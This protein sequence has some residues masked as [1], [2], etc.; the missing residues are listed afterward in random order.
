ML[1]EKQ[2]EA[3]NEFENDVLLLAGAGS[4]KTFT[5]AQK[6]A[7]ATKR[8]IGA[9]EILCLT[10]T[11]KAADE[12]REDATKYCGNLVPEVF[13]IH[14]FC[15]RLSLEYGRKTGRFSHRQIADEIDSGELL[16]ELLNEFILKGDYQPTDKTVPLSNKNLTNLASALKHERDKLGFSFFSKDGYDKAAENLFKNSPSFND[17]F[18]VKEGVSKYTDENLIRF[19][20]R[21]SNEFMNAYRARLDAS[22][23]FDFDD[24]IFCAKAAIF[25]NDFQKPSYKLIIVDEMQD[26]SEAEYEIVKGFFKDSQVMMC[27]DLNQ[28]IYGW[29]GSKPLDVIADFKKNR[30]VK[31]IT[32]LENKRSTKTLA[33]ASAYYL[34]KAFNL[35][36]P[37]PDA[38]DEKEAPLEIVACAG[39]DGEAREIFKRAS[40][41]KG[42]NSEFCVMAR[43]NR[44]VGELYAELQK[45]NARLPVENRLSFFTTDANFQFYKKPIVKDFLAFFR[46][47]VNPDD[48]A[49]I[50]RLAKKQ[51]KGLTPPMI[52]ALK[53]YS[54]LGISVGQFLSERTYRFGDYFYPLIQA[55]RENK[56][57][58]YDLE[59]TGL[60]VENDQAAQISAV[61]TGADGV[62]EV[63]NR[64]I[65]PTKEISA[66][67]LAV[68]GYD[69]DYIE[70]NGGEGARS[71]LRDFVEFAD[72]SV[73]VGHNSSSFDD[74]VLE[75][76][77]SE[78]GIDSN[79]PYKYDTLK[80]VSLFNPL[81]RDY[82]LSTLC[83]SFEITNERA[84]D[85]F[86]DV[87]ATE[88]IL[89][90]LIRTFLIPSA[91]SRGVATKKYLPLFRDLY[92]E[93]QTATRFLE[94]GDYLSLCREIGETVSLSTGKSAQ[95]DRESANDL[96]RTLK[97][98]GA[99]S[100][101][102]SSLKEFLRDVSLSG[103]QMDTIIKKF[104]K[105]PLITAHQSKGCEFKEVIL[106]G[107]GENEL[108]SYGA[109]KSGDDSEERRIFYVALT[110]AK[111]K[112]AATYSYRKDY[113][114][115]SYP[116]NPS[117]YLAFLPEELVEKSR[118]E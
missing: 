75:R 105:I 115:R 4:G 70:K 12:L 31:E 90:I 17:L 32:L 13:T 27:G 33:R 94:V 95:A 85:A 109:V 64:F 80:I 11:V 2:A 8:G 113:P 21:K 81:S 5:V 48:E 101:P 53:D 66:Q 42:D 96:Y 73:L 22:A 112:F 93:I 30:R 83:D 69:L 110:R 63:F 41:F 100:S 76:Q 61:K 68:H 72:G 108:P 24:L 49:S 6:I 78:N 56:I 14:G 99:R 104:D 60:D 87:S 38:S 44:Y 47:I 37:L 97:S 39:I 114:G 52:A 92:D 36:L 35:N 25:D 28:T 9:D 18:L 15:Y 102:I 71:V 74:L 107:A 86:S 79:F 50:L 117:P 7:L 98:Y 82:K 46:L 54:A 106:V 57:V 89:E 77:L 84:H 16:R 55:F 10:F 91:P 45:I 116:R 88:K 67:A 3:V 62:K 43:S 51:A 103:S 65:I 40:E 1:T 26:T 34:N 58:V 19:F 23:L 29:R 20:K 59:T 118:Q 111:E